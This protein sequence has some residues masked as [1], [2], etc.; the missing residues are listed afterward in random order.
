MTH[1][2][3]NTIMHRST[4][5]CA[6]L[7]AQGVAFAAPPSKNNDDVK[8]STDR[9]QISLDWDDKEYGWWQDNCLDVSTRSSRSSRSSRIKLNCDN[10]DGKYRDHY[11]R[12]IHS[13]N[14]PGKGHDKDDWDN[15]GNGKNKDKGNGKGKNK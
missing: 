11:N 6:L 4:L 12:S 7:M 5:L 14:N 13:G 10:M 1:F 8:I 2:K 9:G 15:H 3:R